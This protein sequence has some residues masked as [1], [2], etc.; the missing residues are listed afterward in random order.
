MTLFQVGSWVDRQCK[1]AAG[2]A[3][4]RTE[5]RISA[6]MAG[7]ASNALW[8]DRMWAAYSGQGIVFPRRAG[9]MFAPSSTR[10]QGGRIL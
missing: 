1:L 10:W 7:R 4:C 5:E 9:G 8:Y 2:P 3:V 6:V